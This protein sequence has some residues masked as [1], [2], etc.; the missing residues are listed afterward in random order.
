MPHTTIR[1]IEGDE[2]LEAMYLLPLYSF[3]AT[4][5]LPDKAERQEQIKQRQGVTY[6]AA[7][8]DGAIAACAAASALTQNVRGMIL[9]MAG[10]HNVA[11][12][13][14]A[15]RRGYAKGMLARLLATVRA[16][17]SVVSCLYPFRESFYERI[18][19]VTLPLVHKVTVN[20]QSLL[21]AL[22]MHLAGK[23]ELGLVADEYTAFRDFL[24]TLQASVHGMALF[25]YAEP[26]A[27]QRANLWL[28]RATANGETVGIMLYDLQGE[29]IADF[30][31]RIRRFY[32]LNSQGKYLLLNWIAR[33]VDQASKVEMW[34]P[35]FDHPETWLDDLK[36]T[37]QAVDIAP[38]GRVLDV[39]RIGGMRCGAG[40]FTA[41]ISDAL[42][43]WNEGVW[44]FA[45]QAG[46]LHVS[47][48]SEAECDLAIQAI[49]ALVYGAHDPGDFVWRG[50]GNPSPQTQ[51]TMRAMFPPMMPHLHETF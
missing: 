35:P 7:Y 13:P 6:V 19:Y 39:A 32:Y 40:Q 46:L 24:F 31:M 21:P 43:P 14:A 29:R 22:K 10:V 25:D 11:T 8:E 37:A 44:Q 47:P 27:A 9:P 18:G 20:P 36:V 34:L 3:R 50:W 15:R 23:V 1:Q 16:N 12:H 49:G 26:A 17:G 42:C 4:P 51:D 41:R 30:T 45:A 33:H 28:A 2:I 38:M 5:P 48:A